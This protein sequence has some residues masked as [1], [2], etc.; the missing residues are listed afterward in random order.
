[1]AT[2]TAETK[3]F[4]NVTLTEDEAHTLEII[5]SCIGGDPVASRRRDVSSLLTALRNA[6]IDQR[7]GQPHRMRDWFRGGQNSLFFNDDDEVVVG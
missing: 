5:L 4:V 6:G 3:T 7:F 1:M 2:A